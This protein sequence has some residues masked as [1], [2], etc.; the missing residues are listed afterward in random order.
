LEVCLALLA[1][2]VIG[3]MGAAALLLLAK[4]FLPN[5]ELY[6]SPETPAPP[7]KW[8]RGIL[9]FTCTGVSFAHGSND[10]Q[11]GMGLIMLILVGILPGAYALNLGSH[12][13]A[14]AKIEQAANV[15]VKD[16]EKNEHGISIQGKRARDVLAIYM[17]SRRECT[18]EVPA[19]VSGLSKE[20]EQKVWRKADL[21]NPQKDGE[22]QIHFPN[23]TLSPSV[24]HRFQN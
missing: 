16:F 20:I 18:P 11:K 14:I 5:P 9:L 22:M 12:P 17:K 1:S 24:V 2:P 23:L 6:R 8:I 7:P 3:F 13:H 21:E 4:K 19:A 15:L 10:G